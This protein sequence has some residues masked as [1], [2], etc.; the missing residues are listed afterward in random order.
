M[1]TLSLLLAGF[2]VALTPTNIMIGLAGSFIGTVIG[3][4]PGLGP[5]NGIALLMPLV[6]ALGLPPETALILLVCLYQGAMYG[7]RVSSILL[8]IPGDEPA[9]MTTLDGYPMARKGQGEAALAIGAIASFVGGLLATV[10]LMFFAPPL[11]EFALRFGPPEYFALY[12]VAFAAITSIT[13]TNPWKTFIGT[14]VGLM[15]ATI[16]LDPASG[17]PRFTFGLLE[18]YSGINFIVA[19]VGL[20]A[21]SELL[22]FVEQHYEGLK[23]PR[24]KV[25]STTAAIK[26]V[27]GTGWTTLRSSVVGFIGGVLPGA[28]A[29]LGAFLGYSMERR[30]CDKDGKTF[31]TG[32]K[33]GVAAPEAGNN[34]GATAGLVPM[35]AL[36]IPASA[37]TALLLAMLVALGVTPGPMLFEQ[38]PELVWGLIAALFLANVALLI[39]NLPMVGVFVRML[40]VPPWILMPLV[41]MVGFVGIYSISHSSFDILVMIFFGVLGYGCRKLDISLVP[42]TM[43]LVLGQPMEVNLRR[44]LTL[45]NGDWGVLWSSPLAISLWVVAA[46]GLFLPLLMRKWGGSTSGHDDAADGTT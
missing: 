9:I 29:S 1:E 19:L 22:T 40:S 26:E 7:G 44:A 42:I 14:V 8:N 15:F 31:G 38:E 28:G 6:F 43:G 36:G 3:A 10:A 45:S 35:L 34:A 37:T 5:A 46:L 16:G 27:A 32:D 33:R 12:V 18:L 13:G 39:M 23:P 4:L 11:A 21:V 30:I 17:V 41:T 20:F 24:I 25:G 2:A